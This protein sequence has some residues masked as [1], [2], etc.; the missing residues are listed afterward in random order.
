MMARIR[1]VKPEFFTDEDLAELS[2]DHRLLFQ[3]LWT[4]AD[5]TG[6]LEDRPKKLKLMIFPW[7]DDISPQ[8]IDDMLWELAQHKSCFIIRYVVDDVSYIAVS[9]FEKHQR[10]HP[11]EPHSTIP[12]PGEVTPRERIADE[13]PLMLTQ[14]IPEPVKAA[15]EQDLGNT[16]ANHA[17]TEEPGLGTAEPRPGKHE[18]VVGPETS[19]IQEVPR[20]PKSPERIQAGSLQK[21]TANKGK[22]LA[23]AAID[24]A[25]ARFWQAYPRRVGKQDALAAWLKLAPDEPLV[26]KILGAV[27]LHK[28]QTDWLRDGGQY[29][30]YPASWLNGKR[31]DDE[32]WDDEI[33]PCRTGA[34]AKTLDDWVARNA[35]SL[36]RK[37]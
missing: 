37:G 22:K 14:A 24:P 5:R 12:P 11:R 7:D 13:P 30:P 26:E 20:S 34:P 10:P 23:A 28:A 32:I 15:A 17:R 9:N 16:E 31:W 2:R 25:F 35:D 19:R 6:R 4:V 8:R 21:E 33:K 29:I 1:S 3:G 27:E 18:E 36:R